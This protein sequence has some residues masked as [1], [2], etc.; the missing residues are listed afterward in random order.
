MTAPKKRILFLCTGNAVRSQMSEAIARAFH[1]DVVEAVSAGS[2]PASRTGNGPRPARTIG[3]SIPF[4][5]RCGES[6]RRTSEPSGPASSLP[7]P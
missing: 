1:S 7:D 6:R 3:A 5:A 2:R 4:P